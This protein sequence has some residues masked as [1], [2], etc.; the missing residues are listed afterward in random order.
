MR[1][2]PHGMQYPTEPDKAIRVKTFVCAKC[3]DCCKSEF[4]LAE[5][6]ATQICGAGAGYHNSHEIL[7]VRL[8]DQ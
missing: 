6:A 4:P 8:L 5:R 1:D 3:D 2:V 7:S